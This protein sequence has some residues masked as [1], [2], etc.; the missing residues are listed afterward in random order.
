MTYSLEKRMLSVLQHKHMLL[1]CRSVAAT[2]N[3]SKSS[4]SRWTTMYDT[5]AVRLHV[6]VPSKA[7]MGPLLGTVT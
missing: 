6:T 1:T 7:S 3:V 4:I 5:A 2:Q